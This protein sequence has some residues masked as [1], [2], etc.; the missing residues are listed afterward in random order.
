MVETQADART[1]VEKLTG[2]AELRDR[3]GQIGYRAVM[4]RHTYGHRVDQLLDTLGILPPP[5]PVAVTVLA[6]RTDRTFSTG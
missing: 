3:A 4:S 6:P 5:R 1:A 2:D